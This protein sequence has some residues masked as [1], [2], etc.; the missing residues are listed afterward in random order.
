MS[1]LGIKKDIEQLK[2]KVNFEDKPGSTEECFWKGINQ[3][4]ISEGKHPVIFIWDDFKNCMVNEIFYE[5]NLEK[6]D[7]FRIPE[8]KIPL[9]PLYLAGKYKKVEDELRKYENIFFMKIPRSTLLTEMLQPVA[10]E[11]GFDDINGFNEAERLFM[12]DQKLYHLHLKPELS[13]EFIEYLIRE[14]EKE[15]ANQLSDNN[16]LIK[17]TTEQI[18]PENIKKYLTPLNSCT[19]E[20]RFT[21]SVKRMGSFKFEDSIAVSGQTITL[22]YTQ[23]GQYIDQGEWSVGYSHIGKI[24]PINNIALWAWVHQRDINR[25]INEIIKEPDENEPIAT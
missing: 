25:R 18:I 4:R 6:I 17:I 1:I 19:D 15:G 14:R 20:Y 11:L 13:R 23:T 10:D 7:E 8:G 2:K 9:L 22:K 12:Q 24:L 3:E 16:N 21:T 5:P